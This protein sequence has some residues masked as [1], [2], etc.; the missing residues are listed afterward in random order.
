MCVD[1][2]PSWFGSWGHLAR[3]FKHVLTNKDLTPA[4]LEKLDIRSI[5]C[6]C[7]AQQ[8]VERR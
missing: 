7:R 2:F 6:W 5:L 1:K 3:S 8:G 4:W